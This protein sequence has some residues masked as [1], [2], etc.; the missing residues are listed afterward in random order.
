MSGYKPDDGVLI[1]V[2]E[3]AFSQYRKSLNALRDSGKFPPL[4]ELGVMYNRH[5]EALETYRG[6]PHEWFNAWRKDGKGIDAIA[7]ELMKDN[8]LLELSNHSL[9]WY[10]SAQ[11]ARAAKPML[12]NTSVSEAAKEFFHAAH[13]GLPIREDDVRRTGN[14]AAMNLLNL[15]AL[16]RRLDEL[17]STG[18][19]KAARD[20]EPQAKEPIEWRGG[21]GELKELAGQLQKQGHIKSSQWFVERFGSALPPEVDGWEGAANL[22]VYL[23][24]GL[25]VRKK[26][27][28]VP[29]SRLEAVFGIKGYKSKKDGYGRN[30]DGKPKKADE[31]DRILSSVFPDS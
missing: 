24:E 20:E 28:H 18:V 7:R 1:F 16:N 19:P 27:T 29:Q 15:E 30:S 17:M 25:Q 21:K 8:E 12:N 22:I 5:S 11:M 10:R 6:K 2:F 3:H 23:L 13:N 9:A 26:L 14:S 31:I 4:S